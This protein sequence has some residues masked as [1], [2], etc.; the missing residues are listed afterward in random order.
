[1]LGIDVDFGRRRVVERPRFGDRCFILPFYLRSHWDWITWNRAGPLGSCSPCLCQLRS[2]GLAPMSK[3]RTY[4]PHAGDMCPISLVVVV[5]RGWFYPHC[6]SDCLGRE[7][8]YGPADR[9]AGVL[10]IVSGAL[11]LESSGSVCHCWWLRER[12]LC[13]DHMRYVW[14]GTIHGLSVGCVWRVGRVFPAGCTSIRIDATLRY[15]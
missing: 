14:S 7:T 8:G 1:M 4:Q 2:D 15:E 5:N 12:L 11:F 10:W 9:S 3:Y 13:V 6:F